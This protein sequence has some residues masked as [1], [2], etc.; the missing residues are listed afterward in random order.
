MSVAF[1][2][3]K[4]STKLREAS[5]LLAITPPTQAARFAQIE[6][7]K[8]A[9][10]NASVATPLAAYYK[11]GDV[12]GYFQVLAQM[13]V[14]NWLNLCVKN[15]RACGLS[16]DDL[17][18]EISTAA[19]PPPPEPTK[20][21][22]RVYEPPPTTRRPA[23]PPASSQHL[24][25]FTLHLNRALGKTL[26]PPQ[27]LKAIADR[28]AGYHP[29]SAADVVDALKAMKQHGF[30]NDAAAILS[31]ITDQPPPTITTDER[32]ELLRLF[33]II[34]STHRELWTK[35]SIPYRFILA[36]L[37]YA[38]VVDDPSRRYRIVSAIRLP[39]ERTLRNM[40]AR[41]AELT[42]KIPELDPKPIRFWDNRVASPPP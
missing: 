16:I 31:I 7:N 6:F 28:I 39:S 21:Q 10:Y 34:E 27:K 29:Y 4:I 9:D 26:T 20:Y 24:E 14:I 38:V 22:N 25:Y 19:K 35:R 12:E 41:W 32:A 1:L 30:I 11:N 8:I 40:D 18:L 3:E 15:L 13:N 33:K 23:S 17:E 36:R 2:H 5:R 42:A 37:L